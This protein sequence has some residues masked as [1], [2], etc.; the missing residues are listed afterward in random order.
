MKHQAIS[1]RPQIGAVLA[2]LLVCLGSPTM[3]QA[4][5]T[6]DQAVIESIVTSLDTAWEKGAADSFAAHF[7]ADGF[8]NVCGMM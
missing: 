7:A 6:S 8:T 5:G 1:A 4:Q 3:S 2:A